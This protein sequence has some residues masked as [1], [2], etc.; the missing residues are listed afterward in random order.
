MRKPLEN[1]RCWPLAA[2]GARRA[3]RSGR[4]LGYR[5]VG[6]RGAPCEEAEAVA[7]PGQVGLPVSAA[8]RGFWQPTGPPYHG[9][10][11]VLVTAFRTEPLPDGSPRGRRGSTTAHGGASP[12]AATS[13]RAR[14]CAAR[15]GAVLHSATGCSRRSTP[16]SRISRTATACQRPEDEPFRRE[17][18]RSSGTRRGPIAIVKWHGGETPARSRVG[19]PEPPP[20]VRD[21]KPYPELDHSKRW[22]YAFG[23]SFASGGQASGSTAAATSSSSSPRTRP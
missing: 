1:R 23:P 5:D 4:R 16:A 9:G 14:R 2:A 10:P 13:R 19:T 3:S 7:A 11:P 15:R 21:G 22:G 6:V 18:R 20:I 8:R 12:P 17:R